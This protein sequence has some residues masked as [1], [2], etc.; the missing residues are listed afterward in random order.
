MELIPTSLKIRVAVSYDS[1]SGINQE[2]ADV[3]L[4]EF[5]TLSTF[6]RINCYMAQCPLLL[7]DGLSEQAGLSSLLQDIKFPKVLQNKQV[8]IYL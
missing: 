8:Q 6:E 7:D 5:L 1:F 4:Y 3:S 2:Y